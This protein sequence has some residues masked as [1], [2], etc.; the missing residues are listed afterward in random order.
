MGVG[1]P[2]DEVAAGDRRAGGVVRLEDLQAQRVERVVLVDGRLALA[3]RPVGFD[4]ADAVR[5][6]LV[7][8]GLAQRL[9][10]ATD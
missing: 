6:T 3:L 5:V 10:R 1:V 4:V 9:G 7:M 8:D 2:V